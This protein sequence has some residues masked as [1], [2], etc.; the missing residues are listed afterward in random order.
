MSC[1]FTEPLALTVKLVQVVSY[2]NSQRLQQIRV[3]RLKLVDQDMS[4]NAQIKPICFLPFVL[5]KI[6]NILS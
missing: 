5:S 3:N 2:L 1:D 6:R 4:F